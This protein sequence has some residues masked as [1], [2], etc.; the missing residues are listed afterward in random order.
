MVDN[1]EFRHE[2]F[3]MA[4]RHIFYIA[5]VIIVMIGLLLILYFPSDEKNGQI[6]F[7][8]LLTSLGTIVGFYFGQKPLSE[9][10][11]RLE[12]KERAIFAQVQNYNK[13]VEYGNEYKDLIIKSIV[14]GQKL[15]KDKK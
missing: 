12:D 15:N 6:I 3:F 9:V 4:Q 10:V 2:Y 7:S 1:G 11:S 13:A 8:A 5:I 14:E